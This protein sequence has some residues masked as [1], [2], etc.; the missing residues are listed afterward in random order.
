[1]AGGMQVKRGMGGVRSARGHVKEEGGL[2][3]ACAQA[4]GPE[5]ERVR[6]GGGSPGTAMPGRVQGRQRKREKGERAREAGRWADPWSG[7]R[8]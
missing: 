4:G 5:H 8:L 3:T 2:A 7:S 1:V 6:S